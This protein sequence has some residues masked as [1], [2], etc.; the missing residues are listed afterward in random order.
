MKY[1]VLKPKG[2]NPFAK[3]SRV[4]LLAYADTIRPHNKGLAEDILRWVRKERSAS[5]PTE[6]TF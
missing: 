3:A 6:E 2:T 4:A 1:F 5:F